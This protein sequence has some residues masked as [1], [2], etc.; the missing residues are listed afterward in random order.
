MK[1]ILINGSNRKG[2][3]SILLEQV[4]KGIEK[5]KAKAELIELRKGF[6]TSTI[7]KCV[8]ADAIILGTPNYFNN[9]SALMKKFIDLFDYCWQDKK[10]RGKKVGLI[11]CGGQGEHA[12]KHVLRNLKEFCRICKMK[13]AGKVSVKA[14]ADGEAKKDKKALKNAFELGKKIAIA[15]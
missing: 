1:I 4:K 14:D 9:V 11:V 7:K 10:L 15:R 6:G 8:N 3:T 5:Q 12:N 2:N 13:I